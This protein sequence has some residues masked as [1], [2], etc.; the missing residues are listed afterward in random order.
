MKLEKKITARVFPV[1][2]QNILRC[3]LVLDWGTGLHRQPHKPSKA[4]S[5]EQAHKDPTDHLKSTGEHSQPSRSWIKCT[6]LQFCHQRKNKGFFEEKQHKKEGNKRWKAMSKD[7]LQM[8][9]C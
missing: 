9:L 1:Q 5:S 7:P 8:G 6:T 3:S 2:L 4:N